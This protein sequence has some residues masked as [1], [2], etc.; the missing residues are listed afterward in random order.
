MSEVFEVENAQNVDLGQYAENAYLA[1]A[2]SVVMGRALPMLPDGQKPVQRR[3][4]YAMHR[5][6]L[7]DKASR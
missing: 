2:M 6:G 5:M 7:N 4:L 3:I 1:Y